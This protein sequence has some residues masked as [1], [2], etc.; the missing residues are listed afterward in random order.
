MI[1]REVHAQVSESTSALST[2]GDILAELDWYVRMR[3][4]GG[5]HDE[6]QR[7][8]LLAL[9]AASKTYDFSRPTLTDENILIISN[10]RH[11]LQE[12]VVDQFIP[13]SVAFSPG[14]SFV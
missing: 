7:F 5:M 12:L 4:N 1:S 9:A 6:S 3:T 14:S 10:G 2:V 8:S 13:N 11:P